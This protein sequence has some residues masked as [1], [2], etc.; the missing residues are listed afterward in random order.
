MGDS[1][2]W[3]SDWEERGFGEYEM[4]R[5]KSAWMANG[6]AASATRKYF[7]ITYGWH[8]WNAVVLFIWSGIY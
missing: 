7:A 5:R 4:N 8:W 3:I 1:N 2:E 6:E